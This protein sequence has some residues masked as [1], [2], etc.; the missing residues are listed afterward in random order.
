[1]NES[2]LTCKHKE[3]SMPLHV[4]PLLIGTAF[5]IITEYSIHAVRSTDIICGNAYIPK[6]EF[7]K[8]LSD[9]GKR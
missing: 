9:T 3:I 4:I 2:R 5:L 8:I 6:I 1:M 7:P